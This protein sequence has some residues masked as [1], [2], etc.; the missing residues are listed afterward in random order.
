MIG[1]QLERAGWRQGSVVRF[2]DAQQLIEESDQISF[3]NGLTL[4]VASHSCD[5]A[6]NNLD[7]DPY[8]EFSVARKIEKTDGNFTFNKNP[9]I[10]HTQIE[11]PASDKKFVK[12]SH[13]ELKAFEKLVL[14]KTLLTNTVPDPEWRLDKQQTKSYVAWLAARYSRPEMPTTFNKQVRAADPKGM[15]KNKVKLIGDQLVGIYVHISPD[16]EIESDETYKVNLL[17]LLPAQFSGDSSNA[18]ITINLYAE[19][20]RR[21]GMVVRET[22]HT[23]DQISLERIKQFKRFNYDDISIRQDKPL[24]PEAEHN[25]QRSAAPIG[26]HYS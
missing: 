7:S 13:L 12:V 5:V 14:P 11:C 3:T 4:L 26:N 15:L 6:N 10:L 25:L 8:V 9:R 20:L 19:V 21:A 2:S 17:G 22:L 24:P 23:E 16:S 18:E 1:S